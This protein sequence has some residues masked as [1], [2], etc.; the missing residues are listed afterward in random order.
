MN[1]LPSIYRESVNFFEQ[2][3]L[4]TLSAQQKRVAA[5]ALIA[6]S[7]LAAC[8]TFYRYCTR[9]S[10]IEKMKEQ[11]QNM[12]V[13]VDQTKI[14]TP[15][16]IPPVTDQ[17]QVK[18]RKGI[19]N[20]SFE[21]LQQRIAASKTDNQLISPLGI[22][23]L[24]SMIKHG[25]GPEDQVEIERI[26]HLPKDESEMKASA[27][28]L[29]KKLMDQGLDIAGLLYLNPQYRLNPQYQSLVSSYYQ[30]KVEAGSSANEVNA[31][32]KKVTHGQIKEIIDQKDLVDFFV[33]LANAIHFKASWEKA[34][35]A[36]DTYPA[37]FMTADI[38][39][40][41][42]T[43]QTPM[44]HQ[45]CNM[46]YFEASDCQAVRLKYSDKEDFSMLLVMPKHNNDF[47]FM[48]ASRY[49]EIAKGL[50]KDPIELSL[51]KFKFEQEVDVKEMLK[52]M[53]LENLFNKPDFSPLVDKNHPAS[54]A[55]LKDL[56]ISKMFQKCVFACDEEGT[57]ASAVT[58]ALISKC[59]FMPPE[60]AKKVSF[61]RPFL[62]ALVTEEGIPVMFGVVRDP[63]A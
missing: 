28:G 2:S 39:K 30:S 12:P 19:I 27:Y 50:S 29:I 41:T 56:Q 14:D 9:K 23:F 24:L 54:K 26:I 55:V 18:Y 31:W 47:T 22:S 13:L 44:M 52:D 7:C 61:N 42:S 34:F 32:V 10:L 45:T 46:E 51:P 62:A 58:V 33:V 8:F 16:D 36:S 37:D 6:F 63:S 4:P 20:F 40:P 3:I 38:T 25:V 60:P 1:I 11:E 21:V 53:G 48:T 59:A 15:Q 49:E 5:L 35:K 43:I 17:D 57:E